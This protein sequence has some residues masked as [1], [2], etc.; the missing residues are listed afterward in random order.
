[1]STIEA[2]L[3]VVIRDGKVLLVEKSQFSSIGPGT[4]NAPGGKR[5]PSE[6]F[7]ACACREVREEVGLDVNESD[8]RKVAVMKVFRGSV[9]FMTIHAYRVSDFSGEPQISNACTEVA[10]F[11]HGALP[12]ENMLPGD[13]LWFPLLLG[14]AMFEGVLLLDASGLR[15]SGCTLV[16]VG[17]EGFPE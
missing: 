15:C 10:W 16:L 1:M 9:N 12:F 7:R 5:K 2:T 13:Q 8:L 3:V 14:R 11:A 6:T 17:R 4:W